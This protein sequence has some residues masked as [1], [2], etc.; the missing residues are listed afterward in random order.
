MRLRIQ[1]RLPG[2]SDIYAESG[3]DPSRRG[4]GIASRE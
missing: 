2:D 4:K 1:G 3:W